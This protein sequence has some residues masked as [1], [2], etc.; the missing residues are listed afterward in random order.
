MKVN[1]QND[2]KGEIYVPQQ[3]NRDQKTIN[4]LKSRFPAGFKKEH[5][6]NPLLT[7][8]NSKINVQTIH[9][10]KTILFSLNV[11][12]STLHTAAAVRISLPQEH[13]AQATHSFVI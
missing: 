1:K 4:P 6:I 11:R 9:Y 8:L 13:I 7:S 10:T 2:L 12:L 3:Q 5:E